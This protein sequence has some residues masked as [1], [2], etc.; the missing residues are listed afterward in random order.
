VGGGYRELSGLH[1]K[2]KYRKCLIKKRI[3][4]KHN[5]LRI[6]NMVYFN[7][8]LKCILLRI[9]ILCEC[10]VYYFYFWLF[11]VSLIFTCVLCLQ[12]CM[13][14]CGYV[15]VFLML[16]LYYLFIYPS[17][18]L[19]IYLSIYLFIYFTLQILACPSPPF[20]CSTSHN[21]SHL[22]VSLRMSSLPT[23]HPPPYQNSKFPE[24]SSLL[25]VRCMFP[26]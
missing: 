11:S 8:K 24:A 23:P 2:C 17:I 5:F 21:S 7:K 4:E 15:C 19:F 10:L 20:K 26:D 14:E 1:L 12:I 13:F 3:I 6:W 25:K 18:Y 22:P 16:T 9:L